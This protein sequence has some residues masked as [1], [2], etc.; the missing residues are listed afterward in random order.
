MAIIA[1]IWWPDLRHY[2]VRIDPIAPAAIV[3]LRTVPPDAVLAEITSMRTLHRSPPGI[4]YDKAVADGAMALRGEFVLDDGTRVPFARPFD[5]ATLVA[6]PSEWAL[7]A[8]AF[9]I[10]DRLLKAYDA[11]RDD[12][13]LNAALDYVDQWL[14]FEER[15]YL[16]VGLSWNDH[17]LAERIFVLTDLWRVY[18]GHPR[19]DAARAERILRLARRDAEFLAR[20]DHY[21]YATNHGVMQ[22]LALLHLAM[23]MPALPDATALFRVGQERLAGQIQFFMSPEGVVLEHS[24]GYHAFG[25]QLLLAAQRYFDLAGVPP[26]PSLAEGVARAQSF[27][28]AL[29]RPDGTLPPIGDTHVS[30]QATAAAG[31]RALQVMG[32]D[33]LSGRAPCLVAP[34]SG[35]AVLWSALAPPARD[36]TAQL[37]AIWSNFPGHGHKHADEL[38][39]VYWADGQQWL[40]AAGYWNYDHAGRSY[41]ESWNGANA[42]HAA[43]EPARVERTSQLLASACASPYAM[44]DMERV[45]AT[46][47]RV[48]RQL[49]QVSGE[50][51]F[52]IDSG[53]GTGAPPLVTTWTMFPELTLL[54]GP[55]PDL[56]RVTRPAGGASLDVGFTGSAKSEIH[57]VPAVPD[58][59]G[60]RVWLDGRPEDAPALQ[61]SQPQASSWSATIFALNTR[62]TGFALTSTPRL[63]WQ[64]PD[65][66]TLTFALRDAET[67]VAR[68]GSEVSVDGVRTLHLAAPAVGV[69]QARAGIEQAFRQQA[70]AFPRFRDLT[71][72]RVR[73][74]WFVLALFGLELCLVLAPLPSL[75]VRRQ[76]TGAV[77]AFAL[78]GLGMWL[79][80]YYF[81]H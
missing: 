39:L 34:V 71:R 63:A 7:A 81:A 30:R 44:A 68:S 45:S 69:A 24:A 29:E 40:S 46:G 42:P 6:G 17:A 8:A 61:V 66:W 11:T 1:S 79:H 80:L 55:A 5:P 33:P 53:T 35:Y 28:A 3:A 70:S 65:A 38:S 21:T 20:P 2:R 51:F 49:V 15:S 26:P 32:S 9:A 73:A 19:F 64:A 48:R 43:G 14:A 41:A 72:Y 76:W 37:A 52:V 22:N 31:A 36:A 74:S 27:L 25:L 18:R 10:P 77:F 62:S 50:T 4:S 23:A 75:Q 59:P 67:T 12:R 47:L 54:P 13:Y 56:F 58:P 78:L 16:P 57:A 60:G